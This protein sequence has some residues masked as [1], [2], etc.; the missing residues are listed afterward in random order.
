[1]G[2]HQKSISLAENGKRTATPEQTALGDHASGRQLSIT[3]G[4]LSVVKVD[5]NALHR[6]LKGRHMQMIAM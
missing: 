3:P 2:Y 6:N 4:E 5:Q 1:M